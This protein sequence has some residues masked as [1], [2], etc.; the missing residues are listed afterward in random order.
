MSD[1]KITIIDR[2]GEAHVIDAPTDMRIM[3]SANAVAILGLGIFPGAL[4]ALCASVF[5]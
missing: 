5:S 2:E 3:V 4:M 1:V